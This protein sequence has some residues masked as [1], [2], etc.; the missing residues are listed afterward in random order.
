[1]CNFTALKNKLIDIC[2]LKQMLFKVIIIT[3]K[4]FLKSF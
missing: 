3:Y 1:M 4:G 2:S